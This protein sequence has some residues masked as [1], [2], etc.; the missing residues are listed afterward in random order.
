MEVTLPSDAALQ[1]LGLRV[2]SKAPMPGSGTQA[3]LPVRARA[4]IMD[5]A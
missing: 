4:Y 2:Q 1:G 5:A 3:C